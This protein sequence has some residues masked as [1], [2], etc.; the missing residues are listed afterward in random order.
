M[1]NAGDVRAILSLLLGCQVSIDLGILLGN[2]VANRVLD[3]EEGDRKERELEVVH[4]VVVGCLEGR[5]VPPP[6]SMGL[7]RVLYRCCCRV[8]LGACHCLKNSV[9]LVFCFN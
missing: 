4:L 9:S 6:V 5:V 8:N 1:R 2:Q 7:T 3:E